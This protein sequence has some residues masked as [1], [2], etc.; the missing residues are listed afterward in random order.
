MAD[1]AVAERE[2]PIENPD[3][4]VNNPWPT[5]A[6]MQQEKPFYFYE[7]LNMYCITR[8]RDIREI[9]VQADI[10]SNERGIF[11]SEIKFREQA[12]DANPSE[13]FWP[14]DGELLGYVD[15]PRHGELRRVATPAF[16]VDALAAVAGPIRAHI[17]KLLNGIGNGQTVEWW[18]LAAAVPIEAACNLIGLPATDRSKVQHWSDELEKLGAD[19]SLEE[20]QAAVADFASLQQYITDN[21][22][23]CKAERAAGGPRGTDLISVLLD[24]ELDGGRVSMATVIT[25]AM[26]AMAAGSDTTRALLLGIAHQFAEHPDQWE[27]LRNDRSLVKN[28]IEEVLRWV[29]PA[30]AFARFIKKDTVVNGQEMKAGQY[31]YQMYMAANR[32]PE[33]FVNS[34][35]FDIT[36]KDASRHLSFGAG[37]HICLG[38]RLARMEGALM[39]N[40]MLDRFTRLELAGTPKRVHHIIRN[41]WDTLPIKVYT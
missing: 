19:V 31:I 33:A 16:S 35:Q 20:L 34:D 2:V 3:F 11:P 14:K 28:A 7:P 5:F 39:L 23:R 32:D 15:P 29:T 9:A 37:P 26:T 17:D 30:R 24:A 21:V 41:S 18:D 22:H 13:G 40:A 10:F 8:H 38:A 6:W 27:M 12:G 36:R 4:Y 25:Y 1:V